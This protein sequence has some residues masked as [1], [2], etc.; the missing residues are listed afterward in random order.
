[1]AN[2]TLLTHI[3]DIIP[4]VVESRIEASAAKFW[5]QR[6]FYASTPG[7]TL[8]NMTDMGT[9]HTIGQADTLT[10]IDLY[11]GGATANA[12]EVWDPTARTVTPVMIG[13]D[14]RIGYEARNDPQSD[15]VDAI[16][17]EATRAWIT[18]AE[19]A[20]NQFN[21]PYLYSEAPTSPD[22]VIGGATALTADTVRQG[23]QLLMEAGAPRPYALFLDPVAMGHLYQDS[24][25]VSFLRQGGM[26]NT[27]SA[28]TDGPNQNYFLGN[29]YGVDVYVVPGGMITSTTLRNVMASNRA[30]AYAYK[31]IA[32]P[33]SPVPSELNIDIDWD[34][35]A[36]AFQVSLTVYFDVVGRVFTASTNKWIVNLDSA[37]S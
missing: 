2:E 37:T 29:L 13:T 24:V 21:F 27:G 34:G 8:I 25:A 31:N 4:T 26:A 11:E 30:A 9:S 22:H 7:V 23:M 28:V 32:T 12:N 18:V 3:T 33:L 5:V 1:M 20:S 17:E 36:R 35:N 14:V 10:F 6:P 19:S 16:V 15:P